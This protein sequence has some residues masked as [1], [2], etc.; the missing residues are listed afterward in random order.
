MADQAAPVAAKP[1]SADGIQI[2]MGGDDAT[3]DALCRG[4]ISMLI[5]GKCVSITV[6]CANQAQ[7]DDF[8]WAVFRSNTYPDSYSPVRSENRVDVEVRDTKNRRLVHKNFVE[9]VLAKQ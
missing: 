1:T 2:S 3:F 9:F 6:V 4:V 7:L 5:H 8:A